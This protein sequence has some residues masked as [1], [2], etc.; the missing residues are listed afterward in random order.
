MNIEKVTDNFDQNDL[1]QQ[2]AGGFIADEED[3]QD[4]QDS[5][6]KELMVEFE[7]DLQESRS[8]WR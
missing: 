8:S 2:F 1:L 7:N 3:S 6:M 5:E 4:S